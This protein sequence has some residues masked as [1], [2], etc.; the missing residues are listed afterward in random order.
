MKGQPGTFAAGPFLLVR[1]SGKLSPGV[2]TV[3]SCLAHV[4]PETW[5]LEWTRDDGAERIARA[6]EFGIIGER[7]RDAIRWTTEHLG[8][9][10]FAWPNV[11]LEAAPAREFAR[12]FVTVPMRLLQIW[13]PT[14][15]LDEILALT[16]PPPQQPDYAPVGTVGIHDALARR[17]VGQPSGEGRGFEVLGFDGAAGFDS[18]RCHGLEDDFAKLF[19][20]RFNEHGLFD[21]LD[22]ARRCA[23]HANSP[24]VSTC[25]VAWHPWMVTEYPV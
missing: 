9:G 22:E 12:R 19:G 15:Y 7:L 8:G 1:E 13:L 2:I 23:E 20:V 14:E 25:A 5:A 18:F 3:S 10:G 11:F 6:A 16:T 24:E 4:G 21:D 17:I